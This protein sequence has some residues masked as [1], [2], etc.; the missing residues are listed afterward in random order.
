MGWLCV[1]LGPPWEPCPPPPL[2]SF[3]HQSWKAQTKPLCCPVHS[4]DRGGDWPVIAKQPRA[5][6]ARNPFL[7]WGAFCLWSS[8]KRV[9]LGTTP[10]GPGD[11]AWAVRGGVGGIST[12]LGPQQMLFLALPPPAVWLWESLSSSLCLRFLIH[13]MASSLHPR[14]PS[15]CGGSHR[16]CQVRRLS[17]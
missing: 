12:C 14:P 7:T 11:S 2:P 5:E 10:P 6:R 15:T 9:G 16:V 17:C 4:S 13:E 1:H 8:W 3:P